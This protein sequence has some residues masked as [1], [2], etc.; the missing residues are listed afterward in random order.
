MIMKKNILLLLSAVFALVSCAGTI[1]PDAQE[2]NVYTLSVDKSVI[3]SNGV[4]VA[5][6]T[7][8]DGSGQVLT[9]DAHIRNASFLIVELNEWRSDFL[10]DEK[11]NI[12]SS[13]QDGIFT[14]KAM[15]NGEYCQNEVTV[16]SKNRVQ[17]E[18]FHKNVLLY[19]S[20]GTWC[21][22]CP[23]M[24]K[25]LKNVNQ[26]TK[27]HT[28]VMDIHSSAGGSDEFSID[29]LAEYSR[30]IYNTH[31]FPYCDYSLTGGSTKRGISDIQ[32]FVKDVLYT[33]PAKTGIK[34]TSS[35]EENVLKVNATVY[36]AAEGAYDLA[37]AVVQ[38]G[39]IPTS[40][41][42]EDSY[43]NVLRVI[44]SNYNWMDPSVPTMQK[45]AERQIFLEVPSTSF[46]NA[47][48]KCRIILFTLVKVNGN[49][50]VDNAVTFKV[51]ESVDYKYN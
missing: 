34:A 11:P 6:F 33:Y 4:D 8:K 23:S 24:T 27:D 28:I 50:V 26:Q 40:T 39:C 36:A 43:D 1:D 14:I 2:K 3:E 48:D 7:I 19:K 18:K 12:F 44:S 9:D 32:D 46:K 17:Y 41:A 5:T 47:A 35:L 13:I 51:G 45:D 21:G 30:S 49:T 16:E 31:G 37:V 10:I 38:D 25:N 42:N 15:Y 29:A 20:T 22:Y